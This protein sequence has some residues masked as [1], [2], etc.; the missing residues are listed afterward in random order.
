MDTELLQQKH[1]ALL[2]KN[3]AAVESFTSEKVFR[4]MC[5]TVS[6]LI[7]N[8]C[9]ALC[10]RYVCSRYTPNNIPFLHRGSLT[11]ATHYSM[12]HI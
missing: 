4:K 10:S 5:G 8:A 3:T 7:S 2:G 9:S 11:T 12:Q 6:S 1:A